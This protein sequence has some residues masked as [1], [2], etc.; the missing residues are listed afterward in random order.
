MTEGGVNTHE[1]SEGRFVHDKLIVPLKPVDAAT[2]TDVLAGTPGDETSTCD[3]AKGIEAEKP[4]EMTT[5]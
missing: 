1:A 4:G 3:A 2:I 5:V